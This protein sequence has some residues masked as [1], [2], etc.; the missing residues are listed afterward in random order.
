ML[1]TRIIL[2]AVCAALVAVI[3][4]LPKSVVENESNIGASDSVT[5]GANTPHV[6][7]SKTHTDR[8]AELRR[9]WALE[10]R[11]EKSSIFADSLRGLYSQAGKFDSAAWFAENAATFLKSSDS[12]LKAGNS[13]Y[14]AYTFA[15]DAT[16]QQALAEKAREYLGKVVEENPGDLESKTRIAMTYV[17][18]DSPMKGIRMLREVLETDPKNE[19]ALFNMGMLSVQ[20]GQYDRA[21]ERLQEL[22]AVNPGHIQGQLLLGVAY[23]NMGMKTEARAQF[24]KV[25]SLDKDPSVQ[26]TADSYLNELK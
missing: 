13:Y 6:P 2:V 16:K 17:S 20:S 9:K 18:S 26:A 11:N 14:E 12:Y 15:V 24:E 1:R 23:L 21:I 8:V 4:L 10:G 3:F 7:M 5:S 22:V 25:K 19:F